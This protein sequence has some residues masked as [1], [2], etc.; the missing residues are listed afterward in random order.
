MKRYSDVIIWATKDL[1]SQGYTYREICSY[2]N[3]KI[4]KSTINSWVKN[5]TPPPFYNEKV[6]NLIHTNI[7]HIHKLALIKNR[8]LL[9]DRL[10][11]IRIKNFSLIK[12]IDLP[13]G[14]L[15]LSTLYWCEGAK[16]P[17]HNGIRFGS[18]DPDDSTLR[19]ITALLL[20]HR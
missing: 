20:P 18:S 15:I 19:C 12:S 1:R 3:E 14:I 11:A 13:V 17:S 2:L 5:N 7:K 4:P 16:Y 10:E 9:N 8:E 6:A